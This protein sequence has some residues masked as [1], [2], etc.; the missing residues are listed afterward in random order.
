MSSIYGFYSGAHDASILYIK[1]GEILSGIQE[2]RLSR[3]KSGDEP[4]SFPFLA[5]AEV[6]K[7]TGCNMADADYIATGSPAC[8]K[9]IREAGLPEIGIRLIDHHECHAKAAYLTSGFEGK[10]IVFTYDG[11]GTGTF[12]SIWVAENGNMQLI[13]NLHI[14]KC[15]SLAQLWAQSCYGF[16]WK[17]NKDEGKI[18]GMAGNGQYDSDLNKMLKSV[19]SYGGIGS[20]N[21]LPP[22]NPALAIHLI[23]SLRKL[24]QFS[25]TKKRFDFAY[26][27]Q[28]ITEEVIL[29]FVSDLNSIFPEHS[30]K[31]CFAGGLFANVK[32]NQ[33]INELDFI[34]EIYI[35]PP[36]GDEGIALGAALSVA[37]KIGDWPKPKRLENVFWGKKYSNDFIEEESLKY[38]LK[39][40][41]YES[42]KAAFLLSEGKIGG[43]FNGRFEFGPRSLGARSIIVQAT[44]KNTHDI[45]N[46]RLERHE[47][48]PF[49]PAV[50]KEKASE[51]F[52]NAEK[53]SYSAEFMTNCYTVKENWRRRIPACIHSVDFTGRPQFVNKNTSPEW[54]DL[55]LSYYRITGIPLLLNTSFNGHGEPIIDSPD[56]AFFHLEKETI[57]FLIMGEKI[58]YKK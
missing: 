55:I 7:E 25:T 49:A 20:L 31:I 26:N 41:P 39:S 23:D 29:E 36:M 37:H 32:L 42:L 12:G 44:D 46:T 24:G 21:F 15:A 10:C 52:E 43:F 51:I 18:M 38:D 47:V 22:G 30:S 1:D 5:K 13:K 45:L 11:G 3:I 57:D 54:H 8:F 19:I 6:E 48:M 14:G 58:F 50:L 9:F 53:S 33:K 2:E 4:F 56:Q 17:P 28:F 16:G 35:L 27:L 34:E 40:E